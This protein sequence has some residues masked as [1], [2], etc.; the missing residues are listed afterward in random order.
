MTQP[1]LPQLDQFE[2]HHRLA[3][4]SGVA[5]VV[6]TSRGCASC[7]AWR[8]LLVEYRRRHIDTLVFE[9]DAER[10]L[11]LAREF[12]VYHLPALFLYSGGR[13]HAPLECAA[14]LER[15]RTTVDAALAAPAHEPP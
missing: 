4:T 3:R 13:Y 5:I 10:D 1:A 8:R 14:D 11:A 7:R 6:F 2:F 15:L 12:G 9:V